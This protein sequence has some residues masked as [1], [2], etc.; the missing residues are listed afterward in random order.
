[1]AARE[2]MRD[3]GLHFPVEVVGPVRNTHDEAV[4]VSELARQRGWGQVILVTHPW[5][6]RRAAAA[7]EKAGVKVI[8]V[9]CVESQYDLGTFD[10]AG[11]RLAAFRFWVHETGGY[12][13][14]KLR[15][16]V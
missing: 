6:M 5:H 3:L 9:P 7:F 8:C 4:A 11:D 2:Q 12:L 1:L 13:W 10:T 16:W 15:G 14:Y